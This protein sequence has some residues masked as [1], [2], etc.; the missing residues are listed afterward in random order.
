MIESILDLTIKRRKKI[1]TMQNQLYMKYF[2]V[3][4][5]NLFHVLEFYGWS[6]QFLALI[7]FKYTWFIFWKSPN[8]VLKQTLD[9][10]Y[11]GVLVCFAQVLFITICSYKVRFFFWHELPSSN[12]FNFQKLDI[13]KLKLSI[14]VLKSWYLSIIL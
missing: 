6:T 3:H 9:Q 13:N 14:R 8:L 11:L 4:F 2:L 10:W 5:S 1:Q 7:Q 12:C